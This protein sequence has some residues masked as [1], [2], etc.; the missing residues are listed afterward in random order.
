MV[1]NFFKKNYYFSFSN[2]YIITSKIRGILEGGGFMSGNTAKYL[3][4]P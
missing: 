1:V 2:Y 3:L 4:T